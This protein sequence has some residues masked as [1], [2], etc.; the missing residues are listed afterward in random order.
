M[1]RLH[2][3]EDQLHGAFHRKNHPAYRWVQG[4]VWALIALSIVIFGVELLVYDM[5]EVTVLVLVDRVL[6]AIFAVEIALRV[7]SFRPPA[8]AMYALRPGRRLWVGLTGRLRYML[9]PLNLIDILTVMAVHPAL[10]GLRALRLLRL[11]RS[12]PIFRYSNPLY[13][14]VQ[15]FRDNRTLYLLAFSL[16]GV[17]TGMG[18]LSLYLVEGKRNAGLAT[19]ADGMWWALVTLTTVGYGD[20]SPQTPLG[21]IIGGALMVLG[22][23]LLALFAGVVG[24][25]LLGAVLSIR[26]EQFRMTGTMNHVVICNYDSGARMLLDAVLQEVDADEVELVVFAPG[27]RPADLPPEFRWVSGDPT[28]ESELAKVRLTEAEAVVVVGVRDKSPQDADARTIL[29]LF[30]IRSVMQGSEQARLRRCQLYLVA[31]I[32]DAENVLHA[33]AAGADEVIETTRLGFAMLSHALVQRGTGEI[34]S[35]ITSAG[36]HSLYVGRVPE[37]IALPLPFGEVSRRI[38]TLSG[39]LVL[40][41]HDRK[42]EEDRI[43]PDDDLLVTADSAVIY[44]AQRPVL[45]DG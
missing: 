36:A 44:L 21:R 8:V 25:T 39:A 38:K 7:L 43:N 37:N 4:T 27:E 3:I 14:A 31:E 10:R 18:G 17:S 16:L 32:L 20:I 13:G 15:S 29:T 40:G 22:M 33:R 28:K 34:L 5:R 42:A 35:K 1:G 24:H 45:E 19:L 30:T 41:L 12:L 26:Q 9:E 2:W 11:M 6:L 23:F